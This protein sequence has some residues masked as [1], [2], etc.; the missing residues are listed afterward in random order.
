MKLST[1][2]RYGM[3]A[4]VDLAIHYSDEP[5]PIKNI[6]KRQNISEC[7]LEQLF[8]N[9]RK[10]NLICSIRG[11]QGGY[12]LS[13]A[14]EFITVKEILDVLEGPVEIS[15]CLEE[16]TCKNLDSCATRL[17]W[18]KIKKSIENVLKSTTLQDI[19]DDY[20]KLNN[21]RGV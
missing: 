21:K 12:K 10:A 15:S 19:V 6:S 1:K 14:P 13:R 4:I 7:Y 20:K 8:A 3:K 9:L 16:T 2:G 17:L 18:V 5:V 11:A